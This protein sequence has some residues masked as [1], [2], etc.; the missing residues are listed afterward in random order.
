MIDQGG[1]FT[2]IVALNPKKELVSL[3]VLS[4]SHNKNEF[5]VLKGIEQAKVLKIFPY[6][7]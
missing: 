3:K 7:Q 2:D 1:T 4:H 6:T 5:P